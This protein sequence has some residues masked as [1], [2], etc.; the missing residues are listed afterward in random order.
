MPVLADC[1]VTSAEPDIYDQ[2]STVTFQQ[3]NLGS[4]PAAYDIDS[5]VVYISG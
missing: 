5:V 1:D 4:C 3:H 2:V